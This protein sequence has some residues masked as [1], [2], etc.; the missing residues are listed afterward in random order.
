MNDDQF[1]GSVDRVVPNP[2]F[3]I[4]VESKSRKTS[5]DRDSFK[6]VKATSLKNYSWNE[7]ENIREL[8]VE[9]DNP[10]DGFVG[11]VVVA[12][13][14]TH[15]DPTENITV[16]AKSV[17]IDGA[18]YDLEKDMRLDGDHI[19]LSTTSIT[20]D[21]DGKIE[22]SNSSRHL[23]ESQS[24]V[25]LHGIEIPSTLFPES[26]K[27]QK[28]QVRL[29]WPLPVLLVV[30]IC[31]EADLDLNSSRMQII[32]SQKWLD[33]EEKLAYEVFVRIAKL[34]TANY[35]NRLRAIL[36]ERS[37]NEAFL[38]SIDRIAID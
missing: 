24:R 6:E 37:K 16:S 38:R 10:E 5:R 31:G 30:D 14:E 4:T 2:P 22:Q 8:E 19:S 25:S 9:L 13:L 29:D 1:I 20:I 27:R 18:S 17:I 36:L 21:E 7:H 32:M 28:S 11:S 35:W 26:W 33:F 15:G 12:V 23:A 34:V 3:Q